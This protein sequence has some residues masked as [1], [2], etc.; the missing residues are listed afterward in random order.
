[1]LFN[2]AYSANIGI[3]QSLADS[4]SA[5]L[6]DELNHASIID[7]LRLAKSSG[8]K[9]V[10]YKHCDIEDLEIKLQS[11]NSEK[12][13]IITET[14]FSIDGDIAP[15]KEIEDIADRFN[16]VRIY[17]ETHATGLYG[18]K[19]AGLL[20][21]FKVSND[22][23]IA[24]SNLSKG[25]GYIGGFVTSNADINS[26]L[27]S[28]SRPL[29][30]TTS[31]PAFL[32]ELGIQV[33]KNIKNSS[34]C[35]TKLFKNISLFIKT[36]DYKRKVGSPIISFLIGDNRKAILFQNHI[37][38]KGMYVPCL[39]PPTVPAGTARLRI[40]LSALHSQEDI[41]DL[42]SLLRIEK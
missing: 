16:A 19:G 15:I 29:I 4:E 1:M 25:A 10:I 37:L 36:M 30:Y 20:E 26:F 11:L 32:C 41:K 31:L 8:A 12:K 13:Y 24:V 3:I 40:S 6:S 21:H 9:V 27:L 35:R 14:L 7:G 39:R 18:Y 28:T 33:I 23:F 17:D 2:S 38:G 42:C 34:D 22:N 5:F